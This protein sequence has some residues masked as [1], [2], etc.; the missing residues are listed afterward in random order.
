MPMYSGG[1]ALLTVPDMP[2]SGVRTCIWRAQVA[3]P[4]LHF[5]DDLHSALQL[6]GAARR[7]DERI[8]HNRIWLH[9]RFLWAPIGDNFRSQAV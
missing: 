9:P 4:H 3:Q 8:V 1:L 6:T 2:T 7:C 5:G